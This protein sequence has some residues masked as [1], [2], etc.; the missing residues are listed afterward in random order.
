MHSFDGFIN[1]SCTRDVDRPVTTKLSIYAQP[2]TAF[3]ALNPRFRQPE[4]C[5][6][7]QD[8]QIPMRP[9]EKQLKRISL[10]D[11]ETNEQYQVLVVYGTY[12]GSRVLTLL[13]NKLIYEGFIT[14]YTRGK[15]IPVSHGC[16]S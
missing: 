15:L 8:F 6:G 3:G 7:T 12:V 11:A 13:D 4:V 10:Q 2:K 1:I 9:C 16:P 5:L 14:V